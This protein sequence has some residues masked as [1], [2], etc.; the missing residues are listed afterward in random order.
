MYLLACL[1]AAV[2]AILFM[3]ISNIPWFHKSNEPFIINHY[4]SILI[5]NSNGVGRDLAVK[6]AGLGFHILLG[7][8]NEK[9]AKSFV[10]DRVKGIEPI[11]LDLTEPNH[12]LRAI[13]RLKEIE[14]DLHRN[15]VGVVINYSDHPS[16]RKGKGKGKRNKV[17]KGGDIESFELV[18]L[19]DAYKEIIR[20]FI[21]LVQ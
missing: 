1:L 12:I 7:V 14:R 5:S 19:D 10:Y 15:L 21:R 20:G 13:Y 3:N 16:D 6:L 2:F 17:N 4:G 18:Q 9:E 8:R 11:V